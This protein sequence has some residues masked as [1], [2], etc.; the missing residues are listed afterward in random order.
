MYLLPFLNEVNGI[1]CPRQ[2]KLCNWYNG[3]INGPQPY[4]QKL[5]KELTQTLQRT[6]FHI[7][8]YIVFEKQAWRYDFSLYLMH[9][10]YVTSSLL[11][12]TYILYKS[13]V[14]I[15]FIKREKM[16][17]VIVKTKGLWNCFGFCTY[18]S[19]IQDGNCVGCA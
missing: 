12:V 5:S 2:A 11:C 7:Y 16:E 17:L 14:C 13:S 18:I 8:I 6:L 9:F 3:D 15:T 10:L 1:N 19:Q 4:L